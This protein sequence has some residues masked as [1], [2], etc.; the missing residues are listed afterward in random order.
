MSTTENIEDNSLVCT[1]N[2]EEILKKFKEEDESKK[3]PE[4]HDEI[5]LNALKRKMV[6]YTNTSPWTKNKLR[7][8]Y[9]EL[10]I[11]NAKLMYENFCTKMEKE[12]YKALFTNKDIDKKSMERLEI[13]Y[14][15][16]YGYKYR[17]DLN[18]I[19]IRNFV[20]KFLFYKNKWNEAKTLLDHHNMQI[21]KLQEL[22]KSSELVCEAYKKQIGYLKGT[23]KRL[24]AA[25]KEQMEKSLQELKEKYESG[26]DTDNS[27]EIGFVDFNDD[28][29]NI[30]LDGTF[31]FDFSSLSE[32]E[33]RVNS[34]LN[35]LERQR[36]L[37]NID[38]TLEDLGVDVES[39]IRADDEYLNF[40]D[41][42]DNLYT[43]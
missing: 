1:E 42:I 37:N 2:M 23:Y 43:D 22:L 35:E 29:L 6:E 39:E 18:S 15:N 5:V 41:V 10:E 38:L 9:Q 19:R 17:A 26:N 7:K 21:K 20:K 16:I 33:E 12:A 31:D 34:D 27:F 30:P 14:G 28:E 11:K 13:A 32:E 25:K 36:Q 8:G 3:K 24:Y 4:P 40:N